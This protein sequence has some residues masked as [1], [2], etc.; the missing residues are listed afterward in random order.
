MML[1]LW[2]R[3]VRIL[4]STVSQWAAGAKNYIEFRSNMPMRSG[5]VHN[6]KV[7]SEVL[8]VVIRRG[9]TATDSNAFMPPYNGNVYG[10]SRITLEK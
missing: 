4:E 2:G 9:A 7:I 3:H 1:L 8:G 6:G 10:N 5:R